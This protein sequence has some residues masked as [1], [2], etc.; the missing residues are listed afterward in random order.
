MHTVGAI[1]WTR[2][3]TFKFQTRFNIQTLNK[4]KFLPFLIR[5]RT[6]LQ[7]FWC[8]VT[9]AFFYTKKIVSPQILRKFYCFKKLPVL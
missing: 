7:L 4:Y 8:V 3:G 9:Q 6:F 5:E 2:N 1:G